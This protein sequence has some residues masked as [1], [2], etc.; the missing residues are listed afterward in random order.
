MLSYEFCSICLNLRVYLYTLQN[1]TCYFCRSHIN[2]KHR[3]PLVALYIHTVTQMSDRWCGM[4]WI[5]SPS[6]SAIYSSLLFIVLQGNHGFL[7]QDLEQSW[8][9][10]LS[11]IWHF[12]ARVSLVV[13]ISKQTPLFLHLRGCYLIVHYDNYTPTFPRV[14]LTCLDVVKCFYFTRE[15]FCNHPV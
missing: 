9:F 10:Q 3:W 12:Y 2:N 14:F 8:S 1:L 13:C 11:L 5:K 7:F 15:K 4:L 6:F